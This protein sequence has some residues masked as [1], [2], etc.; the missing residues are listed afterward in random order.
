MRTRRRLR[1][2]IA[3]KKWLRIAFGLLAVTVVIS[4]LAIPETRLVISGYLRG[5]SLYNGRPTGYWRYKV[6]QYVYWR[7]HPAP[8][9]TS[10]W[11]RFFQFF[12]SEE[13]TYKPAI[14]WGNPKAVPVLIDLTKERTNLKLYSEAYNTLSTLG[15]TAKDAIPSLENDIKDDDVYRAMRALGVLGHMGP[16]GV[17]VVIGALK[18]D[19]VQVRRQ[20]A[21]EL[22]RIGPDAK[23]CVPDLIQALEDNDEGVRTRAAI[24]LMTIDQEEGK[25]AGA[26]KFI[27][28]GPGGT[29]VSR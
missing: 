20:A 24:S 26:E 21:G 28:Q 4:I 5:E 17:Q 18:D 10:M 9:P 22:G 27:P 15:R 23:V 2:T 8:P 13:P 3:M 12:S 7:E 11:D 19:R 16:D 1:R 25:K 29:T 6:E 14:L